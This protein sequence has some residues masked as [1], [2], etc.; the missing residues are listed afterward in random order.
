MPRFDDIF[1]GRTRD[2]RFRGADLNQIAEG[3]GWIVLHPG[4]SIR[5]DDGRSLVISGVT[6]SKPDLDVLDDLAS[7]DTSSVRV[8]IFN[9]DDVFPDDRILPGAPR[10]VS[11]PSLAE[12]SGAQLVSFIQGGKVSERVPALFPRRS[13]T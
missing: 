7:R 2:H 4:E 12:Y 11:T 3:V 9:P 13:S 1:D 5:L 6:W 8:W 10:M